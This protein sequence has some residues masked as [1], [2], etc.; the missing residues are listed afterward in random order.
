MIHHNTA[1]RTNNKALGIFIEGRDIQYL[2]DI[3][4]F[5]GNGNRIIFKALINSMS[6]RSGKNKQLGFSGNC[7][8]RNNIISLPY[9][10]FNIFL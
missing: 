6:L 10:L 1:I 2:Y 9:L 7:C 5:I 3:R 4:V 8:I